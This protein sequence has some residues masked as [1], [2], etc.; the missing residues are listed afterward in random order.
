MELVDD[1][2]H[3]ALAPSIGRDFDPFL[4]AS[5]GQDRHGQALSVISA[6]ARLDLD[7]WQEAVTLSRMPLAA[8]I[9]R[10]SR[11][12]AALPGEPGP[13][14]PIEAVAGDLIALLPAS[15][16]LVPPL[17]EKVAAAVAWPHAR[18]GISLGA[19]ALLLAI[20]LLASMHSPP[21]PGGTAR[22]ESQ[23]QHVPSA[24]AVPVPP[25]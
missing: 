21:G 13:A 11:L 20:G 6:L 3:P 2:A 4:F 18:L 7:P 12:I 19:L 5:I 17:P 16:G 9:Q 23:A 8:A 25:N 10:L 14:R 22:S 15:R 1:M 24:T